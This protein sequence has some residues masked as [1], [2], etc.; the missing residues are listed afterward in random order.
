MPCTRVTQTAWTRSQ[1]QEKRARRRRASRSSAALGTRRALPHGITC[2]A[3]YGSMESLQLKWVA[4]SLVLESAGAEARL[5]NAQEGDR[6]HARGRRRR[7]RVRQ[8][9]VRQG[10]RAAPAAVLQVQGRGLL[11]QGVPGGRPGR[12]R[13][14]PRAA[15]EGACVCSLTCTR[16]RPPCLHPRAARPPRGRPGTSTVAAR[17]GRARRRRSSGAPRGRVQRAQRPRARRRG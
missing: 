4:T 2:S 10:A 5:S 13:R 6:G 8:R 7:A 9:G 17:R 11:L 3:Q 16:P 1:V 12:P 15:R 14:A